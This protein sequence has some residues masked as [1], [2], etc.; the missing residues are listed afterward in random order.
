VSS[1]DELL[2]RFKPQPRYD[3]QEAFFADSAAEMTDNP[4][5]QLRRKDGEVLAAVGNGLRLEL[6]GAPKYGNGADAAA[7]DVL[8]VQ[9]KNYRDQYTALRG[10]RPD[11]RNRIYGH[12]QQDPDGKL[13][14]QYWFWY[15]YNDYQ[16]AAGFGLH[17]GDWEM[18]ELRLAGEE[19]ELALYAQH[20]YAE[21]RPWDDVEKTSDGR[22][23][24][25]PGRGS[26]ASYFAPGLYETEGWYDIVDGKR[27]A[28]ELTL[29]IVPGDE[30]GWI[31]WPGAWGDT[32]PR[33]AGLEEPS[34]PGPAQH[35]YW[36]HPE[37]LFDRAIER[38][39][40][41]PAAPPEVDATI[42]KG[43]E[44]WVKLDL[45]GGAGGGTPIKLL[46]TVDSPDEKGVPPKTFTFDIRDQPPS[47]RFDTGRRLDPHKHYEID[48]SVIVLDHDAEVP[49]ASRCIPLNPGIESKLPNWVKH[50]IWEIEQFVGGKR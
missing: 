5:N 43:S 42:G 16:L 44:L 30:P 17:E 8:G 26:H 46:A 34:P 1:H 3:S 21:S 7:S 28:P 39:V 22:P 6:L 33:I 45:T 10:A 23:V 32:K 25:Y 11:L 2:E 4:G 36:K 18:V 50:P 12:A 41:T 9:G 14:L 19:P 29:E 15:F 20:A 24:S 31:R 49:S 35:P 48:L 37:A 47:G 38:V 40:K 13:W 27:A